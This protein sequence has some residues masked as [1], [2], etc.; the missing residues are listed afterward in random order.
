MCSRVH[1]IP[2][3]KCA[4]NTLTMHFQKGIANALTMHFDAFQ[5][6]EKSLPQA[7]HKLCIVNALPGV[8]RCQ[9]P[10]T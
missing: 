8:I 6:I 2:F 4:A 5:H 7:M 9:L 3:S 1:D 10:L